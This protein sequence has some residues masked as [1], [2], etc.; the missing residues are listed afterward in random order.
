MFSLAKYVYKRISLITLNT[1]M[2]SSLHTKPATLCL[3]SP[4]DCK[5]WVLITNLSSGEATK[6]LNK[7]RDETGVGSK[8][9]IKN[10][11]YERSS[12]C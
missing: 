3:Q 8:G 2:S 11:E 1:R 10:V 6:Y 4:F 9:I 12:L 5:L 7:I